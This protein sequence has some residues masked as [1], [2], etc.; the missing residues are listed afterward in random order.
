MTSVSYY[1]LY[2]SNIF[3]LIN[4]RYGA[5]QWDTVDN[6]PWLRLSVLST[7]I[8]SVLLLFWAQTK[9]SF[10]SLKLQIIF[11]FSLMPALFLG[12]RKDAIFVMISLA[13][14]AAIRR[15]GN[16]MKPIVY[17]VLTIACFNYIQAISR[18]SESLDL[19]SRI[20]SISD[21]VSDK[22]ENSILGQIST[23]LPIVP[24]V[25]AAIT[26]FPDKQNF[27][28]GMTYI[29]TIISAAVP[30]IIM[31]DAFFESPNSNFHNIYYP[32]VTDFSMDY[33]LA[34][35]GYQN[36]GYLGIILAYFMLGMILSNLLK[37]SVNFKKSLWLPI[38]LVVFQSGMW[39][40]R[41]DSNTFLKISLYAVVV[42]F[43][44]Y[45]ASKIP[46]GF[47]L[48]FGLKDDMAKR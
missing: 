11:L 5:G 15:G 34:A 41:S 19:S 22:N 7:P 6:D 37:I 9:K 30:K 20:S 29:Q 21:S 46:L 8:L 43:V 1:G 18:D 27:Y 31:K 24:T 33:S 40:L 25:T 48:K 2:K 26:V 44:V 35:E 38:C 13:L 39:N 16:S 47:K 3:D 10:F 36:F 4:S 45:F 14:A 32:D 17:A 42:L 23:A 28:Y 12:G